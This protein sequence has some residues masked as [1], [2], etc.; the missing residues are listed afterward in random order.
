[1]KISHDNYDQLYQELSVLSEYSDEKSASDTTEAVDSQS[2]CQCF[3]LL[4][5]RNGE[6]R[7]R[8]ES[9]SFGTETSRNPRENTL[10]CKL[11]SSVS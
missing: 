10:F 11:C 3:L 5:L 1:M 8:Q 9:H 4:S 2:C 6:Q 7:N